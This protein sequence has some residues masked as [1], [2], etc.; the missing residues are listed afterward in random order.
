MAIGCRLSAFGQ[1][2]IGASHRTRRGL[3]L[4]VAVLAILSGCGQPDS[5]TVITIWHQSRPSEYQLLQEEIKTFEAAHPNVRVRALYKETEE[6]R[7]GFQAAALAGGGPELIYGPSDVLGTLQTMGVLQDMG[8]WFPESL[9]GDFVEGALTYLP[10][11]E[12]PSKQ[13]LVQVGD[14][15]G[16][17]LALVYN[18]RFIQRLR[19]RRTNLSNWP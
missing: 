4:V 17:H 8:P 13:D 3:T 14:R 1:T 11:T 5:R 15:F 9:R 6:L 18:R 16:N 10:A 2:C 12:D 7:S 19:R